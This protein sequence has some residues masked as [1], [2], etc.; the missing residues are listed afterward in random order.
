MAC[1]PILCRQG[2]LCFKIDTAVERA[3]R[4]PEESSLYSA[5]V[6][7][8]EI[9]ALQYSGNRHYSVCC[10][11][12]F[13]PSV[14]SSFTGRHYRLEVS[15]HYKESTTAVEVLRGT[16]FVSLYISAAPDARANKTKHQLVFTLLEYYYIK[17]ATLH[18]HRYCSC[19]PPP[20]VLTM[21]HKTKHS[22]HPSIKT[23]N[24]S[25]DTSRSTKN[26][27][28]QKQNAKCLEQK[29][30]TAE[31]RIRSITNIYT[32]YSMRIE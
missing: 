21:V 13:L 20:S 31:C 4:G 12:C 14:P 15:R 32:Y 1:L 8:A 11:K 6:R 9:Q 3:Q 25:Q 19:M 23:K 17:T 18:E 24:D 26:K 2:I 7:Q 5:G 22:I 28:G 10:Q 16:H 29:E 30:Q 27:S